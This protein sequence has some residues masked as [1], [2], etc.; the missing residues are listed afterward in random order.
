L[1]ALN[2]AIVLLASRYHEGHKH[3]NCCLAVKPKAAYWGG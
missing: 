1:R 2:D 3:A